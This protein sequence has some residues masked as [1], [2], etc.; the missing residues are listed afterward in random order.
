[1]I[2]IY[3]I[4]NP[5]GKIYIGQSINIEQRKSCYKR[6]KSKTQTKLFNSLQKYGWNNHIF[7]IVEICNEIQLNER[8]IFWG[9][10]YKVLGENGLNC[11]ELGKCGKHTQE[12]KDK[13]RTFH[14][15]KQWALGA[16]RTDEFK[17]NLRIKMT[18]VLKPNHKFK[19]GKPILQYDLEGNFIKEWVCITDAEKIHKKGVGDVLLNKIIT[20]D[21]FIWRYKNNPI[22]KENFVIPNFKTL[23]F[24]GKKVIQ[25]SLDNIEV[26]EWESAKEIQR[27]LNIQSSNISDCCNGKQ[28]TAKG[29]KWKFK[30]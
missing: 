4:I 21:N 16:K 6:G 10:F 15:G 8:E 23:N 19:I 17:E 11:K 24:N 30:E 13:M 12:S 7:E 1:M 18:G 26:K 5:K 3:K 28:K 27:V 9:D 14:L 22:I 2:G 25:L 20:A 29:F